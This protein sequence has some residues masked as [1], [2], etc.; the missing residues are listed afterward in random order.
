MSVGFHAGDLCARWWIIRQ[1]DQLIALQRFEEVLI[2]KLE[3]LGCVIK[4]TNTDPRILLGI[5]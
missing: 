1:N 3:F 4:W 5:K 2:E